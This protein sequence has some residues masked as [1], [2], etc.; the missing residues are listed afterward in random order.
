MDGNVDL[1]RIIKSP[2]T[3]LKAQ[4][5][6]KRMKDGKIEPPSVWKTWS[7]QTQHHFKVWFGELCLENERVKTP[8]FLAWDPILLDT[9]AMLNNLRSYISG[10]QHK[11]QAAHDLAC[12]NAAADN[13]ILQAGPAPGLLNINF[14]EEDEPQFFDKA[15][16]EKVLWFRWWIC[17]E[18]RS[19]RDLFL[20]YGTCQL[21][22]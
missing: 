17:R 6:L 2:V 5:Q 18:L 16:F 8:P 22:T 20:I 4:Q 12:V 13:Q 19:K 11:I 15:E 21:D 14:S 7:A 9:S 3:V 10:I 1:E